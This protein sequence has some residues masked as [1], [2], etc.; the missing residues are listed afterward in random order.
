MLWWKKDV[1][2]LAIS[3]GSTKYPVSSLT[4][5]I[6]VSICVSPFLTVPPGKSKPLYCGEISIL[7]S[8]SAIPYRWT[9]KSSSSLSNNYNELDNQPQDD[10]TFKNQYDSIE[11]NNNQFNFN[12]SLQ[13][14]VFNIINEFY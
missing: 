13:F 4:S 2:I 6:R 10:N 5:R 11:T 8:F 9:D 14:F 12:I 7:L 1:Y 3:L